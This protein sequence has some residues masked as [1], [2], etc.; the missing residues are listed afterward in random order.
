LRC[1]NKAPQL[2]HRVSHL[3]RIQLILLTCMEGMVDP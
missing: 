1:I 3:R 2:K